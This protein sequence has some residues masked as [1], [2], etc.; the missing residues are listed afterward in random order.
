MTIGT[1]S[2][3]EFAEKLNRYVSPAKPINTIEFLHGRAA[4]LREIEKALYAGGRNIFIYGERGVG[5]S[6][7]A[8]TAAVQ[9]QSSD[10]DYI[11]IECGRST[12][13]LGTIASITDKAMEHPSRTIEKS[14]K[15]TL[16]AK[17]VSHEFMH[18]TTT[19]GERKSIDS[20]DKASDLMRDVA[21]LHSEKPIVVID[22]FDVIEDCQEQALFSDFLK[23]LGDKNIKLKFIFSGVGSSLD[24]LLEAHLSSIRQ[25][26]TINLER[27]SWD[28]R[29]EITREA[30]NAF[31]T[32]ISEELLIRVAGI[33]DGFPY[34][35]HLITEKL[36]W[37]LFEDPNPCTE[38]TI[39]NYYDA[40]GDA[41]QGISP[42]LRKSYD[43]VTKNRA[44]EYH[45]VLWAVADAYDPQRTTANVYKSYLR[46]MKAIDDKPLTRAA[47]MRRIYTL[48]RSNDPILEGVPK[49]TG[50]CQF[51]E[52]M[53]RGFV[54]LIA[55]HHGISLEAETMDEP[56]MPTATV[57][58]LSPRLTYRKPYVP[59]V[60]FGAGKK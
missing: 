33:S 6:S 49:R 31:G 53:V 34:Y 54:R 52:S 13:F 59:P 8:Q 60:H 43:Q 38:I 55:E 4:P 22:E 47:F 36:F 37:R 56:K 32:K 5:K 29:W 58:R 39:E 16:S 21:K 17:I 3:Q 35:V 9:Y 26:E 18:K 51:S 20:M 10:N 45:H 11:L 27:L 7:L 42:H 48:K 57:P 12:T 46:I 28:A 40:I 30:A 44:L 19:H 1:L 23:H 25:L 15:T 50:W 2:E 14:H 41:I 24:D